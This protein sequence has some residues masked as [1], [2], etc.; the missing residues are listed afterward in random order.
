M[1]TNDK[2]KNLLAGFFKRWETKGIISPVFIQESKKQVL[3]T[4]DL[5]IEYEIKKDKES[6]E[7]LLE[8]INLNK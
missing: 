2:E 8:L 3:D 1:N 5:L 6:K 7:N 4:F